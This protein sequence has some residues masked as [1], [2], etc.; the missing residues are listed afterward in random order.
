[1]KPEDKAVVQQALD[2]LELNNQEW[3][4]LA[5][6]GDCGYWKAEDQD[7]YKQ[8]SEAI[9]AL[10]QLLEQPDQE[11]AFYWDR[12]CFFVRPER[13]KFLGLDVGAMQ[14]LYTNPTAQPSTDHSEQDLDMADHGDELT[15]A[16]LNGVHTGKQM[17]K[18]EW[19]GLTD[20]EREALIL[21]PDG[22]AEANVKRVE[23]LPGAWGKEYDEVDAWSKPLILQML[24]DH[25]AK[26]REKNGGGA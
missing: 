13:A 6:S 7:H 5:D 17:A 25:E 23:V 14:A 18:R 8:T 19:V 10:R 15:I 20:D 21:E 9:A 24:S 2:A 3:K 16:Y 12:D 26:L 4:N 11:P 22:S 1:M